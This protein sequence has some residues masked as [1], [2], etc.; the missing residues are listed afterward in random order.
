MTKTEK[1][2][3][4]GCST[5]SERFVKSGREGM[6][7]L[8]HRRPIRQRHRCHHHGTERVCIVGFASAVR[9]GGPERPGTVYRFA[10]QKGFNDVLGRGMYLQYR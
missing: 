2:Q 3:A 6:P 5:R 7:S 1:I 10:G 4:S 8:M 9:T